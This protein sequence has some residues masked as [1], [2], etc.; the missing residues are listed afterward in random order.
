M[1]DTLDV[2]NQASAQVMVE[3]VTTQLDTIL[4]PGSA[5]THFNHRSGWFV[6]PLTQ[7]TC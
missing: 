1:G 5:Y 4:P 6:G 2:A 7:P 3:Q